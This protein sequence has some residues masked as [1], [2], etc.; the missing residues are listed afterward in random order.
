MLD[1]FT[2]PF[3]LALHAPFADYT[4]PNPT[5]FY[6]RKMR[7][8]ISL[9]I[10]TYPLSTTTAEPPPYRNSDGISPRSLS[11][12]A[13]SDMY[14]SLSIH[15]N[16][17]VVHLQ[18]QAVAFLF[19]DLISELEENSFPRLLGPL[20]HLFQ[21]TLQGAVRL[22]EQRMRCANGSHSV[23][24][25]VLFSAAAAYCETLGHGVDEGQKPNRDEVVA[26]A[27]RSALLKCARVVGSS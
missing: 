13:E 18:R 24:E 23:Q 21:S 27:S 7:M 3:V 22:F 2:R 15:G 17:R 14:S 25:F 4:F 5:Y 9:Q 12:T 11:T 26:A 19:L 20:C 6:S 1:M 16:T 8:E 10:L